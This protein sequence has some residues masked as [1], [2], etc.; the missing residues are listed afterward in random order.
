LLDD[1]GTTTR[2]L[3]AEGEDL[4]LKGRHRLETR[5]QA[6]AFLFLGEIAPA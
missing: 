1:F 4:R 5:V 2:L 6:L 3:N